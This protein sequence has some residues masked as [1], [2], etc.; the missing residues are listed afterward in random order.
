MKTSVVIGAKGTP[1]A[2][3]ILLAY[4]QK[5]ILY[6]KTSI[7]D[8]KLDYSMVKIKEPLAY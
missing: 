8:L 7:A 3:P 5:S 4:L 2:I 6:Q 1:T